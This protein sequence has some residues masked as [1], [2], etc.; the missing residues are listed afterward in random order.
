MGPSGFPV[1]NPLSFQCLGSFTCYLAATNVVP[2]LVSSN[3]I[4]PEQIRQEAVCA[5]KAYR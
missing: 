4:Y 2:D 3:P 5:F 1:K